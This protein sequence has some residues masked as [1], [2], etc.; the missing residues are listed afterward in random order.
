VH[1]P[2]KT[3]SSILLRTRQ[4]LY[5]AMRHLRRLHTDMEHRLEVRLMVPLGALIL[6]LERHRE[7]VGGWVNKEV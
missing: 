3:Y 1:L 6:G 4:I 2:R 7:L 5:Q